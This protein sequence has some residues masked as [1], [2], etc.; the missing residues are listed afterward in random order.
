MKT[1][2]LNR[3]GPA[4]KP[5]PGRNPHSGK[6]GDVTTKIMRV[7]HPLAEVLYPRLHHYPEISRRIEDLPAAESASSETQTEKEPQQ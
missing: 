1:D 3:Q 4:R 5:G 7:P 6:Y 2:L